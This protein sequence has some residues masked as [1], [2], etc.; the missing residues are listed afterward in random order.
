MS[1]RFY[2]IPVLC[3]LFLSLMTGAAYAQDGQRVTVTGTVVDGQGEPVI[4][5]GIVV[6]G[7][8]EGTITDLDGKFSIEA[9]AGTTLVV[10]FI[11]MDSYEFTAE[12]QKNLNVVLHDD[13]MALEEVVVVGYGTQKRNHLTGAISIVKSDKLVQAHRPNLSIQVKACRKS[14]WSAFC[15]DQRPSWRGWG[16][17]RYQGIR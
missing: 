7:T 15:A 5:A 9:E 3:L 16:D 12:G 2:I 4:G 6:K 8:T 14:S 17:H 10:S 13:T 11:G 1:N